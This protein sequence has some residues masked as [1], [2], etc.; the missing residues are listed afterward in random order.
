MSS[1]TG[2]DSPLLVTGNIVSI[3]ALLIIISTI[4]RAILVFLTAYRNAPAE[5][6]KFTSWLSNTIDE[7]SHRLRIGQVA[8][9]IGVEIGKGGDS[10]G[11]WIEMLQEYNDAHFELDEEP[12]LRDK[13]R[14]QCPLSTG[15]ASSRCSSART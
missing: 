13:G 12:R 5:L 9:P 2:G 11:R 3:V 15:T 1:I 7:N 8:G 4:T 14:I 10:K 6:R